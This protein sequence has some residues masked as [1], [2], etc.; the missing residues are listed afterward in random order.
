MK[1]DQTFYNDIPIN[2]G[3]INLLKDILKILYTLI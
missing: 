2:N 1:K 3:N